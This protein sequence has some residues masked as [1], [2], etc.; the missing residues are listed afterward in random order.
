M[1]RV[2][3]I[4]A[5]YVGLVTG[6]CFA[7]HGESVL[8]VEN[9]ENKI[10]S[11]LDGKIPFYEPGLD[12]IVKKS[13]DDGNLRFFKTVSDV[14]KKRPDVIFICV[15]TPSSEDSSPDLSYV[16][17][18]AK[19]IG[20]NINDYCLVVNKSTVPVGTAGEVKQIIKEE[21]LKRDLNIDFDVASNP[22]FLKEGS[23]ILDFLEPDRIVVGVETERAENILRKLYEKFYT[24]SDQF[25]VMKVASAELTKYASNA[26]LATRIS[27]INQL[28]LLSDAVGADI[29][30]VKKGLGKDKRIGSA[31]LN[32][33]IGYGGSCFPKDLKGLISIGKNFNQT[34]SLAEEVEAINKNQKI[35]FVQ[36]I[37]KHYRARLAGKKIGVWGIAFKPE[38]DDI[39]CAPAIDII[40]N[41]LERG[42]K[43]IVYDPIA[44]ENA[45]VV[46][47][48]KISFAS[49][50]Q[51]VLV[52]SDCLL[53]LTEWTEFLK[54]KPKDFAMLGDEVVFDGRNCFDPIA[55]AMAGIEYFTVGRDV[56][57]KEFVNNACCCSSKKF[58][59]E[60][61]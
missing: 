40:T 23:A 57:A 48:D 4:G 42:C 50:A 37:E 60:L 22:E 10:Q 17:A 15:G 61:S 46:F 53:I 11:L 41:L 35:F 13:L 54:F 26:M 44:A 52:Q 9:N 31:F 47:E 49:S 30:E 3:V 20:Q 45:K 27:F 28:A 38:T 8:I 18:V 19:E 34:M 1:K 21:L 36:K 55:M 29:E 59:K 6:A 5:G 51:E 32:A 2:A 12:S 43:V 16:Y 25:M 14:L 39:R 24:T 58:E 7:S 56:V 33:G